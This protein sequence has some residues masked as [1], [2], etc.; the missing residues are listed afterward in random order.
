[1]SQVL[2]A[3]GY[4][5]DFEQLYAQMWATSIDD[6]GDGT[7]L[8]KPEPDR[9]LKW[10]IA[11]LAGTP[12][13]SGRTMPANNKI[14]QQVYAALAA[15]NLA[16][17]INETT[18]RLLEQPM[19]LDSYSHL[20]ALMTAIPRGRWTSYKELSAQTGIHPKG[21]GS[22]IKN[23]ARC[24]HAVRVLRSKGQLHKGFQWT[25]KSRRDD[26]NDVLRSQG[27]DLSTGRAS[28]AQFVSGGELAALVGSE[29]R[30]WFEWPTVEWLKVPV[31]IE[32]G[33]PSGTPIRMRHFRDCV[34]WYRDA[35][36]ELL[37]APPVLA[38]DEQMRELP[39]CQNCKFKADAADN[40]ER[41][42]RMA[43]IVAGESD[44]TTRSFDGDSDRA[45]LIVVRREQRYLRRYL[46]GGLDEAQCALCGRTLPARVLVAAHIAPRHT[47]SEAERLNFRSAA[48]LACTLG[49]DT[50][51]ELGHI[52][53]DGGGRIVEHRPTGNEA[54][55][56]AISELVGRENDAFRAATSLSFSQH[57]AFHMSKV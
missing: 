51:F 50:L 43:S 5:L 40:P 34:H 33:L 42:A 12:A 54:L 19:T 25:E 29:G 14:R 2:R 16:E 39:A 21:L 17:R 55:R 57:M 32:T 13:E 4:E 24:P 26:P 38:T 53:V 18:L 45:A 36:G 52:A 3:N 15:E 47:L 46:L 8:F 20:H 37:G 28:A 23:C 22:H 27:V 9:A 56:K 44:G 30:E 35:Q 11:E 1:M 49:C 6:R 48:M 7:R 41:G 31:D 10:L